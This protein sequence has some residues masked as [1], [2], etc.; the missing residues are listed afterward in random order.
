VGLVPQAALLHV[1]EHF[2]RLENFHHNQVLEN[3]LAEALQESP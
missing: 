2:L 3:R 1:A